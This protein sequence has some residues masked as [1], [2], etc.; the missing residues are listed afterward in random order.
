MDV[1]KTLELPLAKLY[2]FWSE[3]AERNKW[4]ADDRFSIHKATRVQVD[5]CA[6]GPRSE[7]HRRR[8]LRKRSVE[9]AGHR[10]AQPQRDLRRCE[11]MKAYWAKKIR[12]LEALLTR[13]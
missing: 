4:L 3:P 6:L 1:V 10:A 8:F 2:R 13:P 9:V 7:P 11:Q 12:A 5:S